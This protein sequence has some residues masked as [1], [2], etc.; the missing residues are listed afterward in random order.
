MSLSPTQIETYRRDGVLPLGCVLEPTVVE[1]ARTHLEALRTQKK[2]DDPAAGTERKSY[3]LLNTSTFDPWFNCIVTNPVLLDAAEA[4]LGPNLQFF[5]DNVFYKPARDGADTPWHQDNIWWH[6]DPPNMCTIWIALDHVDVG[7]GAVHYI[8]G[9][10]SHLIEPEMPVDDVSGSKYKMLSPSQIE[11][12]DL[13]RAVSFTVPAG[14]AV[15][16]HCL[17]LHGAPPNNSDRTRRGYTVHL[18]QPG[19][20]ELDPVKNPILRGRL[21]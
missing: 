10:H 5:Q 17:T 19:V 1:E 20:V 11:K 16:H 14:H 8:P 15:M 13:T 12:I 9:S 7:N 6:A 3:R 21:P 18:A 4:V 2:M